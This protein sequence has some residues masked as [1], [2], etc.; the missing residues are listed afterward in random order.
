MEVKRMKVTVL[1]DDLA[2]EY[3]YERKHGLCLY[4]ET[5]SKKMLFDLGP[6]DTFIRNAKKMDI[7]LSEVDTVVISHGHRDHGGGLEAFLKIN[8]KAKVYVNRFAFNDYYLR[9]FGSI[10]HNIGL[11]KDY[12]WNDRVVLVNGL[13]KVDEGILLFNKIRGKELLPVSNKNLLKKRK[14]TYVEDD[15]SHEQNLLIN[16]GNKSFVFVGCGH[17]GII[18]ILKEAERITKSTINYFFGGLHLYNHA[19]K[20]YEDNNLIESI[21]KA[22]NDKETLL[23]C[24]HCTGEEAYNKLKKRLKEKIEIIKVGDCINT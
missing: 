14:N 9:M 20:K 13:Y 23:Y 11:N 16:E 6:N 24:C 18:N 2:K 3:K 7:D 19:N 12:K 17:R 22:L 8:H 5:G 15:F 21:A 1:V 10:K 4:I